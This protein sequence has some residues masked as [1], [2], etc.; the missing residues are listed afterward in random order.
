MNSIEGSETSYNLPTGSCL[1]MIRN[2][3]SQFNDLFSDFNRYI[4]PAYHHDRCE[5]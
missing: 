5:R 4:S 3:V 2:L 1:A